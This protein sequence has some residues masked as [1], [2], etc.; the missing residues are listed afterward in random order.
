[1]PCGIAVGGV[2]VENQAGIPT[3]I[4]RIVAALLKQ[5]LNIG[6]HIDSGLSLRKVISLRGKARLAVGADDV[7]VLPKE[8]F[9]ATSR[10]FDQLHDASTLFL[11]ATAL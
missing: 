9:A 6:V 11:C 4:R 2:Y 3:S 1:M 10:A 8:L 5:H 7:S